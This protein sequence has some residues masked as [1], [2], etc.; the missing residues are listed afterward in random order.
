MIVLYI[1]YF[2]TFSVS[3]L[4]GKTKSRFWVKT[5]RIQ[6]NLQACHATFLCELSEVGRHET[7]DPLLGENES[8]ERKQGKAIGWETIDNYAIN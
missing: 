7:Q 3:D 6:K 4:K 5:K 1:L 2:V 8:L